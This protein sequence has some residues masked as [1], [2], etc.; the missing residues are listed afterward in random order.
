MYIFIHTY[1]YISIFY[2]E[3]K[4]MIAIVVIS[5]EYCITPGP[6]D[7]CES[8]YSCSKHQRENSHNILPALTHDEH[9]NLCVSRHFMERVKDSQQLFFSLSISL[10]HHLSFSFLHEE[11]WFR[12]HCSLEIYFCLFSCVSK[13][14]HLIWFCLILCVLCHV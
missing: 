1:I 5:L 12:W 14:A 6:K 9:N 11:Q 8:V 3:W 13:S 10:F 4:A 2:G 7:C